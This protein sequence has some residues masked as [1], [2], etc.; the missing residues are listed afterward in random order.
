MDSA[1]AAQGNRH[2]YRQP[3]QEQE[4]HKHIIV[5][6]IPLGRQFDAEIQEAIDEA[7]TKGWKVFFLA[8]YL[9]THASHN[10]LS[11]YEEL[12]KKYGKQIQLLDR[13]SDLEKCYSSIGSAQKVWCCRLHIFLITHF[14][15][16][17]VHV[18]G[19]QK[20]IEKMK[21]TLEVLGI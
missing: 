10:D 4:E 20:K 13:E 19:Y 11:C 15:G 1:Y 6:L 18:F 21:R 17:P 12:C 9:T 3:S 7:L 16:T 14:I 5:N 8:A 2:T